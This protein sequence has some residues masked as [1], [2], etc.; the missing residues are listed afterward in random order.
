VT[1]QPAPSNTNNSTQK[2]KILWQ[3]DPKAIGL[4]GHSK[5]SLFNPKKVGLNICCDFLT[6]E[7]VLFSAPPVGLAP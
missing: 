5:T 7:L 1:L 4:F 2:F 6:C 3:S